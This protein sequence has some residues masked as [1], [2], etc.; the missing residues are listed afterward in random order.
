[1]QV[2]NAAVAER[3]GDAPAQLNDLPV[4]DAAKM[5]SYIYETNVFAV[6]AVTN[7]F[8]PLLQ[9]APAARIVNV[10]SSLGSLQKKD[11]VILQYA[12]YST[13]KTALNA[14]TLHYAKYLA[15]TTV[16]INLACPGY[17][18]TDLNHFA[19][20]RSP[21]QGADIIIK[22]AT[23]PDDGPHGGYFDDNGAIPW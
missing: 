1:M 13:S 2:N 14:V 6:V 9:V 18:G 3:P 7:A 21:A 23:L 16:K 4:E 5:F 12:A 20:P 10:S 17:C 8:L 19:G 11:N 15:D 22:L